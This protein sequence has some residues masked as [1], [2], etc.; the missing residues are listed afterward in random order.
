MNSRN[1]RTKQNANFFDDIRDPW[2]WLF[3]VFAVLLPNSVFLVLAS[4]TYI[5][6]T[7]SI[8]TYFAISIVALRAPVVIVMVL[9]ALALCFDLVMVVSIIFGL[10][11]SLVLESIR[12]VT[13]FDL[14]ASHTYLALS[15]C[16]V[17]T[18]G[19]TI[20]LLHRF[21][22]T[23]KGVS[24]LPAMLTIFAILGANALGGVLPMWS[25]TSSFA[26]TPDFGS[27]LL[28]SDIL[29]DDGAP[30]RNVL[31]VMVEGMGKFSNSEHR[32]YLEDRLKGDGLLRRYDISS[33]SSPY[34]GSTTGGE[35]RE[36][37]GRWGDFVDF[38]DGM[39]IDCLP[40]RLARVGFETTS[41]HAFSGDFFSR[42]EWYPSV[43]FNQMRFGEDM[44]EQFAKGEVPLCGITFQGMCDN[45]VADIVHQY[46]TDGSIEPRFT[47]WLT[48][49]SHIPIAPDEGTNHF[50]CE[51]G[52][53]FDDRFICD[54]T[55]MWMDVFDQVVAMANDPNLP[56]T[57]II[58]V[59]DHH[60]PM[61]TRSGRKQFEKGKVSWFALKHRD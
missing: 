43:G 23:L 12:Y 9:F 7:V 34:W 24:T 11:P 6:R 32:E 20:Y 46:L 3:A 42:T 36:L 54:M 17:A 45:A 2:A 15:V 37:C 19:A 28:A 31:F 1:T 29:S 50:N 22:E 55:E 13:E 4:L 30:E 27:A 14:L 16:I 39:Q 51:T 41:F 52:G 59:G 40:N 58:L 25:S 33:G 56:P 10:H 57:D 60:P 18:F 8:I 49:N 44:A 48:L 21:S 61:W 5:D 26:K 38:L 35:M 47:Y 53:P